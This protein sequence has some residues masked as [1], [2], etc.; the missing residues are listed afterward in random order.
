MHIGL[1]GF[2]GVNVG[3]RGHRR[4][5]CGTSDDRRAPVLTPAVNSGALVCDV[6]PGAPAADGR[7]DRR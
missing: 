7:P 5:E 3:R 1:A 2:M 4:R 6:Y